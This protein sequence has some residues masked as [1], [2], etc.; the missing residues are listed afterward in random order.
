[1]KQVVTLAR[2]GLLR[3]AC[4]GSCWPN[5]QINEML[6]PLVNQSRYRMVVEIIKAPANQR[7]TFAGKVHHRSR[8]IEL[9]VKPW[10]YGMLIRRTDVGEVIRHKRADMTSYK[11]CRK[12][13]VGSRLWSSRQEVGKDDRGQGDSCGEA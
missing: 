13:L 1:M 9:R 3:F 5:K 8:K 10:F 12:E 4:P 7:K 2:H 6:A 11:L